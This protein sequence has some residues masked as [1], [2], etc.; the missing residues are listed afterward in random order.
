LGETSSAASVV[1]NT[2][3]NDDL[4]ASSWT[5]SLLPQ[6]VLLSLQLVL[7]LEHLMKERLKEKP[8]MAWE[9]KKREEASCCCSFH[10]TL[11][12]PALGVLDGLEGN[13]DSWSSRER[14]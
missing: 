14:E 1:S 13:Q 10:R 5:N 7:L 3:P 6:I 8:W 4:L 9:D 12:D 2:W 11:D